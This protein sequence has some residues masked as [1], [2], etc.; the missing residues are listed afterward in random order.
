MRLCSPRGSAHAGHLRLID[1][2]DRI[3][4]AEIQARG[5]LAVIFAKAQDNAALIGLNLVN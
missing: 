5:K 1:G 4:R 3:G 2:L